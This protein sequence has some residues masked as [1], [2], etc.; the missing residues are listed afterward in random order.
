MGK[1]NL[2]DGLLMSWQNDEG[3]LQRGNWGGGG[4]VA[5]Y[6]NYYE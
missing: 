5:I 2:E 4:K 6:R 1:K 3:E